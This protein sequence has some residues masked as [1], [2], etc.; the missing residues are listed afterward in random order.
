MSLLI[1]TLD[2]YYKQ[3]S[4]ISKLSSSRMSAKENTSTVP[5]SLAQ[6]ILSDSISIPKSII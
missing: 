2:S 3:F 4:T 1:L 5:T 6:E